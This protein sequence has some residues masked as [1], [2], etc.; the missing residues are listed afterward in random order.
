M[1]IDN[2]KSMGLV[3]GLLGICWCLAWPGSARVCAEKCSDKNDPSSAPVAP[4]Y[5]VLGS[6]QGES[7]SDRQTGND[8]DSVLADLEERLRDRPVRYAPASEY[9]ARCATGGRH[10]RAIEFFKA[11]VARHPDDMRLRIEL[12]SAYVDKIPTCRGIT[13]S[14]CQGSLARKSLGQLDEVIARD[15]DSWVALFCRG[16][17][18]LH[19]PRVL[20]H[21]DDAVKDFNRCLQLQKRDPAGNAKPYYAHT[22]VALGDAYA[23]AK[24]YERAIAAW[25]E[26][27]D[28]F[29]NSAEL[30]ERLAIKSHR[31][32]LKFVE[33]KRGLDRPVDTALAFLDP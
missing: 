3:L 13:K 22:H 15:R 5:A 9:R 24:Q 27:L 18:H 7:K 12:A 11:L 26:G 16:M 21:A 17:N 33:R 6:G 19:W 28:L 30:K 1:S 4:R 32:M 25:Q 14:I 29:P 23:K 10:D 2:P 8:L 20:R 31:A